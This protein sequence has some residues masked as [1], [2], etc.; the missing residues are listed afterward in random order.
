MKYPPSL[1]KTLVNAS[2]LKSQYGN[3][4]NSDI[5]GPI[6]GLS[7]LNISGPAYFESSISV[8]TLEVRNTFYMYDTGMTSDTT[9][10]LNDWLLVYGPITGMSSLYIEEESILNGPVTAMSSLDVTGNTT[11]HGDLVV[12]GKTISSFSV[13]NI[14][15]YIMI[16]QGSNLSN[17]ALSVY[18]SPGGTAEIIKVVDE[19]SNNSFVVGQ[20][21]S[22]IISN[23]G[24]SQFIVDGN[25]GS[26]TTGSNLF[27]S[28][29][30]TLQNSVSILSTLNVSGAS[31][32]DS[33][34]FVLD[35]VTMLSSLGVSGATYLESIL[36]VTDNVTLG[37]SLN[38]SGT[39]YLESVL[40]VMDSI[41]A[42]NTLSVS[43]SAIFNSTI[44]VTDAVTLNSTLN[45]S[46]S[47]FLYSNLEVNG[48]VTVYSMLNISGVSVFNSTVGIADAITAESDLS[49]SGSSV[50]NST[51]EVADH[52]T[53]G[54]ALSV[55]GASIFNSTVE[56]NNAATL[57]STLNVTGSSTFNSVDTNYLTVNNSTQQR[58]INTNI[59]NANFNTGTNAT[60][61]KQFVG[62]YYYSDPAVSTNRNLTTPTA[63]QI[64][65]A[66]NS[67]PRG[68]TFELVVDNIGGTDTITLTAGSNVTITNGIVAVNKINLFKGLVISPTSVFLFGTQ[69]N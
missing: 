20:D 35:T 30:S 62:G 55:S 32:L 57:M 23:S 12:M 36:N 21:G 6:T 31:F 27:V 8:D 65:S 11:I 46:G 66:L 15:N 47:S 33:Y 63:A 4:L 22:I 7:S 56:I 18:Q 68:T 19:D 64:V 14:Y 24:V 60:T 37:S 28:G 61:Q 51:M 13:F 2:L 42:Y 44:E 41:S 50:F 53:L 69:I 48:D 25:T 16:T 43:G 34:L 1:I 54:S 58:L 29:E 10:T 45:V 52:V 26:V 5:I 40:F 3:W 9:M 49:V 38:I 67:A 17:P 39:T 59:A